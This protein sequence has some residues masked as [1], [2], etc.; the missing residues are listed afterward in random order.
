[1]TILL[2][3]HLFCI[4]LANLYKSELRMALRKGGFE[5]DNLIPDNKSEIEGSI[6]RDL[7]DEKTQV[8]V[9]FNLF[10]LNNL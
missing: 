8:L 4:E 9:I 10:S 6:I 3:I 5:L 7:L 1:M 2:L